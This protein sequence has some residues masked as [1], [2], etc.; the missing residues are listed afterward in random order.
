MNKSVSA[1]MLVLA[2]G[3]AFGAGG[4]AF[5]GF[6]EGKQA[7]LEGNYALAFKEL[8][9]LAETGDVKSSIGMGLLYAYGFGVEKDN[10]IAFRWF[11]LAARA[12]PEP[13]MVLRTLAEENRN[14]VAR[15]LSAAQMAAARRL[16]EPLL[17]AGDRHYAYSD[18]PDGAP[19]FDTSSSGEGSKGLD[20]IRDHVV[21][22]I[23]R[24]EDTVQLASVPTGAPQA[25]NLNLGERIAS[26]EPAREAGA[27][28]VGDGH[29]E[30]APKAAESS[31]DRERDASEKPEV[32]TPAVASAERS[33]ERVYG[34]G[35]VTPI[36]GAAFED[37]SLPPRPRAK[38]TPT[39]LRPSGNGGT[40]AARKS[41]VAA[42]EPAPFETRRPTSAP[43]Q[44]A[45]PV[46]RNA[47]RADGGSPTITIGAGLSGVGVAKVLNESPLLSGTLVAPP[48]N[49]SILPG[50][51]TVSASESRQSL[52][53]RMK[54]EMRKAAYSLWDARGVVPALKSPEE[55]VIL[56]SIVEREAAVEDE[57]PMIAGVFHNRLSR[58]MPLQADPTVIFALTGGPARLGRKLTA[59]DLKT[60]SPF[61]TYVRKGL[62][63]LPISNPGRAAIRAVLRPARTDYLFFVADGK[64]RHRFAK[65]YEEH[66]ENTKRWKQTQ[67]AADTS[68]RKTPAATPPAAAKPAATDEERRLLAELVMLHRRLGRQIEDYVAA[69]RKRD[70]AFAM[71]RANQ[72]ARVAGQAVSADRTR[73]ADLKTAAADDVSG[74]A[75]SEAPGERDPFAV[76]SK[77]QKVST[78]G[79][80]QL[81][82]VPTPAVAKKKIPKM[83]LRGVMRS[84]DAQPGGE[85]VAALLDIKGSGVYVVREGDTIGLHDLGLDTVMKIVKVDALSVVVETGTLGQLIIVR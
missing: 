36:D 25:Q 70:P 45:P 60:D 40:S 29:S 30:P 10:A 18:W 8:K 56:A 32:F 28:G 74:A 42:K 83:R 33:P 73:S 43:R 34:P 49:G 65:T 24:V 26:G 54:D 84:S 1:A 37:I 16:N 31:A 67:I 23:E 39:G 61:N 4:M 13:H 50:T 71:P 7:F 48:P 57:M 80:Q 76:P 5:A 53:A 21:A 9:P 52:L 79:L 14:V 85:G 69:A 59:N 3:L 58:D 75:L 20:E 2:G 66:Q 41:L 19:D 72:G 44:L 35:E 46:S 38:P 55:A 22:A 77:L 81:Q 63:P 12:Q 78:G 15:G 82:F 27:N 17:A 51:Y 11:D 64:G 62:P 6:D 68:A 47:G